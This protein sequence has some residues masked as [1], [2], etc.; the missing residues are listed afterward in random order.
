MVVVR[1]DYYVIPR[2]RR[3]YIKKYLRDASC[4]TATK[5]FYVLMHV[6]SIAAD[7]PNYTCRQ[8][9]EEYADHVSD[10]TCKNWKVPYSLARYTYMNAKPASKSVY[11]FITDCVV[12]MDEIFS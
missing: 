10:G 12:D 5:G 9:F 6:I 1:S 4:S 7:H 11:E 3:D 8:M 2:E